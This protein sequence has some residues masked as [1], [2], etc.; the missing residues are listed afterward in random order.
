M[1]GLQYN[2]MSSQT[3]NK[4]E[5]DD[6]G[7]SENSRQL[8][9]SH[10]YESAMDALSSLISRQKRSDRS[11]VGGKYEKLERMAMYLK[12]QPFCNLLWG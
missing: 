4:E 2:A 8:P 7:F 5:K 3:I 11:F 12:V 9:R 1:L 10:S 6:L